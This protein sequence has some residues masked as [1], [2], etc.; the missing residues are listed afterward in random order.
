HLALDSEQVEFPEDQ[1]GVARGRI[2][3]LADQNVGAVLLVEPF[4]ARGEVHRIAHGGVAVAQLRAHVADGSHTGV[5]PNAD[6]ELWLVLDR[7][8]TRLNSSHVANS[9]AVFCL[10]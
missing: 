9:Y 8:S 2:G 7:K 3:G 5:E 10:K 1:A 6:V 4:Q